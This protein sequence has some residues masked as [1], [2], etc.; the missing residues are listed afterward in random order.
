[1][2]RSASSRVIRP[3]GPGGVDVGGVQPGLAQHLAH[4]RAGQGAARRA[5]R[6][7][8]ARR[9][10]L[11]RLRRGGLG[12]RVGR[13]RLGFLVRLRLLVGGL[14]L[15]L[16]GVLLLLVAALV[17]TGGCV[18][19]ADHRDDLA[20]LDGVVDLG[21][22]LLHRARHGGGDL[23][24]DLVRGD[25]DQGL[26][27]L[28]GVADL[29]EPGRDHALLDGLT[30]LGKF[31]VGHVGSLLAVRRGEGPHPCS[32]RPARA[33]WASPIASFRVGWAWTKC[34]TSLGR[35]SQL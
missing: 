19:L 7:A 35:A 34:A 14:G 29:D 26:V 6:L 30:E 32:A 9:G 15:V 11:L 13:V 4:Q 8:R 20:D 31:D 18:A 23:G 28:D 25:L 12:L 5:T 24:V 2:A 17:V 16:A 21:A 1:M 3:P 27:D 33:R 22:Q 10:G